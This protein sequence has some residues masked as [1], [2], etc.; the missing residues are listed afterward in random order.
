MSTFKPGGRPTVIP[1]VSYF[2]WSRRLKLAVKFLA[3]SSPSQ[4]HRR[5]ETSH[6]KGEELANVLSSYKGNDMAKE[7]IVYTQPG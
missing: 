2:L 4:H 3:P 7:V 5:D 6:D 1:M